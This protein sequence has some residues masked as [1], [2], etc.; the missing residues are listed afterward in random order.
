M[1]LGTLNSS[2]KRVFLRG[3][4]IE[5]MMKC[6]IESI[7]LFASLTAV[8]MQA[9]IRLSRKQSC[10]VN[11]YQL[12]SLKPNMQWFDSVKSTARAKFNNHWK[13]RPATYF[14][15]L[16]FSL[17]SSSTSTSMFIVSIIFRKLCGLLRFSGNVRWISS[18]SSLLKTYSLIQICNDECSDFSQSQFRCALKQSLF[19]IES[20]APTA[21]H[22]IVCI[23]PFSTFRTAVS[24]AMS[25]MHDYFE[26]Y[27]DYPLFYW[28]FLVPFLRW[29]IPFVIWKNV[30]KT[31]LSK[32][33]N[34]I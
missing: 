31:V 4:V 29:N 21:L 3:F 12:F 25:W 18:N 22:K 5:D 6:K 9:V 14:A 8:I 20:W 19:M 7:S 16:C 10:H 11:W 26:H 27:R 33:A 34:N 30:F 28:C 1:V 13:K 2:G 24:V 17:I 15:V 23:Y 32:V